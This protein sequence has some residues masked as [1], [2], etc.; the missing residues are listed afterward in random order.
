MYKISSVKFDLSHDGQLN[1]DIATKQMQDLIKRVSKWAKYRL[2]TQRDKNTLLKAGFAR[3]LV[4]N[5]VYITERGEGDLTSAVSD[6]LN[7]GFSEGAFDPSIYASNEITSTMSQASKGRCYYCES[8][9][10]PNS[11][12]VAHYRPPTGYQDGN[13]LKRNAYYFLAYNTDNLVYSCKACSSD[14]KA[15]QFPTIDNKHS[16]AVLVTHETPILVN[17]RTEDPRQFIRF[18]VVSGKA[19]GFDSILRFYQTSKAMTPNQVEQLLYRD[20]SAIPEQTDI[21]EQVISKPEVDI[22]YRQWR[23]SLHECDANYLSRGQRSIEILNLNRPSL[24]RSR[25]AHLRGLRAMYMQIFSASDSPERQ[26]IIQNLKHWK[27]GNFDDATLAQFHSIT[28]DALNTWDA[29]T[30][31]MRGA[32]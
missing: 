11:G 16:P 12:M 19:Y 9:I 2:L 20:P 8:Q 27:N 25:L 14:S 17:P 21:T 32:Q 29:E 23:Q 13:A 7:V 10:Q 22:Q 5:L 24:V 3:D 31:K 30:A 18:N 26:A 4:D 28:V 1:V 6:W 15:N